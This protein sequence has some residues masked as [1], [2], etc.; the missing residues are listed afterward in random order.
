MHFRIIY[1]KGLRLTLKDKTFKE[2][3][4]MVWLSDIANHKEPLK[5]VFTSTGK[6][7]YMDKNAHHAF[8]RDDLTMPELIE[9]TEI[10]ELY[11]N[12]TD[13]I[14]NEKIT[15]EAG[16]LWKLRTQT[17]ILVDDEQYVTHK[18]NV[19]IFEIAEDDL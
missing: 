8:L 6:M 2:A 10:D 17:L 14:S 9:L 16:S 7:L 11:R 19:D 4:E 13:V 5:M 18:L 3:M 12:K 1:P 15:I